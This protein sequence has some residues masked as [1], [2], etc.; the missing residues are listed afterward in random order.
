MEFLQYFVLKRLTN[1]DLLILDGDVV[2]RKI[3]RSDVVGIDNIAAVDLHKFVC[4]DFGHQ[5]GQ[6]GA[7]NYCFV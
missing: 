5:F 4:L 6:G 3:D 7:D 1:R 2:I